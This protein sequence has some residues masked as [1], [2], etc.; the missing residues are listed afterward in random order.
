[1]LARDLKMTRAELLKSMSTAE[2]C[3]WIAFYNVEADRKKR[4]AAKKPKGR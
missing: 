3:G 4:E 2:F 1:M